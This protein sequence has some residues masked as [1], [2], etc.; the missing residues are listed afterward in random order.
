MKDL[1]SPKFPREMGTS[2]MELMWSMSKPLC[3]IG[4]TVIMEGGFCVLRGLIAMFYR[5]IYNI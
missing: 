2:T 5:G 4:K 3:R 1:G